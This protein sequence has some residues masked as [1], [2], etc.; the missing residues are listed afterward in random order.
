RRVLTHAPGDDEEGDVEEPVADQR[1]RGGRLE[2]GQV[3]IAEHDVPRPA[4]QRG[5]QLRRGFD[6]LRDRLEPTRAQGAHHQLGVRGLVFDEEDLDLPRSRHGPSAPGRVKWNVAPRS[7]T[8]SA[9]TRPPCR[10]TMRCT[11]ASPTPVP[12]NSSA[13]CRRPNTWN[14]LSAYRM[15]NPTPL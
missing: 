15:S 12:S 5:E 10:C 9:H 1:E 14:S 2:G 8:L 7:G 11:R 3:V 4:L 13:R 6:A